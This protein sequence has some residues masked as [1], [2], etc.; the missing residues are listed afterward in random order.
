MESLNGNGVVKERIVYLDVLNILACIAVITLHHNGLVFHFDNSIAWKE[1]LFVECVF[2][3][4]VPVF[5][6]ISGA[7]LL[8]YREKYCT[9]V[10][11]KKRILR[12]V[13]PWLIWS[14]IMLVWKVWT[15][16]LELEQ[17]SMGYIL[18][19][20]FNFQVENVYWF[21]GALFACY[22]AIPV[23]SVLTRERKLLWY[24]VGLNF[25]FISCL[26]ALKLWLGVSW[27]LDVPIVGSLIIYVL[28]GYL[29]STRENK[30]Y[31][32]IIL[33][34]LGIGG[35]LFRLIYTYIFSSKNQQLD[36]TI[37]GYGWFHAVFL[38]VAVFVWVKN[39]K[40]EKWIPQRV[41]QYLPMISSCSFG[42]YL[43]HRIVMY[44]E[45]G[46]T[47]LDIHSFVWRICFVPVTYLISLFIIMVLKKI[48]VIGKIVC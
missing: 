43:L 2:Y 22:M 3:W 12:T 26:P 18:N 40:W 27:N 5:L 7:N 20:I 37:K 17:N 16:Q 28:L 19:L 13:I 46:I 14:F 44:Y 10:F 41:L 29:F 32:R 24:T 1:S 23:F 33:Y 39:V 45:A 31:L 34:F 21:F 36:S 4:A 25:F 15:G 48:P 42:V 11:F 6:M 38:S 47:G 30:K 8:N 35:F 9:K